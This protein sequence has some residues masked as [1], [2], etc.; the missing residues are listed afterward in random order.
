MGPLL[1]RIYVVLAKH[2]RHQM[3]LL[4]LWLDIKLHVPNNNMG[5]PGSLSQSQPQ[6]KDTTPAVIGHQTNS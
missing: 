3:M 1:Q 5:P 2:S 4:K 6:S